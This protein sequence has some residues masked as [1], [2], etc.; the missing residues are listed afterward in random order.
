MLPES[1]LKCA[2]RILVG[3]AL[4]LGCLS[5]LCR[6]KAGVQALDVA[7]V[8]IDDI[9]VEVRVRLIG[10]LDHG[11]EVLTE[12]DLQPLQGALPPVAVLDAATWIRRYASQQDGCVLSQTATSC[13]SAA[14]MDGANLGFQLGE[15]GTMQQVGWPGPR[16]MQAGLRLAAGLSNHVAHSPFTV[17]SPRG[18]LR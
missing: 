12:F 2:H 3:K 16:H 8:R 5:A 9:E 14:R 4:L 13:V 17:C 6:A 15:A 1:V 18:F 7:T 11:P 10:V